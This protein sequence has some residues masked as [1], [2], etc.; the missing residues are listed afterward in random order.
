LNS[1]TINTNIVSK[2]GVFFFLLFISFYWTSAYPGLNIFFFK[3]KI[4]FN[5]VFF[6]ISFGLSVVS[7]PLLDNPFSGLGFYMFSAMLFMA[8]VLLSNAFK[9]TGYKGI[10]EPFLYVFIPL[11]GFLLAGN[12][13]ALFMKKCIRAV[14]FNGIVMTC[15]GMFRLLVSGAPWMEIIDHQKVGFGSRN[16]DAYFILFGMISGIIM[17]SDIKRNGLKIFVMMTCFF[18]AIA[19]FFSFSRGMILSSMIVLL[20]LFF[21]YGLKTKFIMMIVLLILTFISIFSLSCSKT[22][23]RAASISYERFML[24]T[25]SEQITKSGIHNSVPGRMK[26][27]PLSFKAIINNP[28][29]GLGF[30]KFADFSKKNGIVVNDPHNNYLLVWVELG[31]IAFMG[32]LFMAALPVVIYFK[33]RNDINEN[34]LNLALLL[35]VFTITFTSLFTNYVTYYGYWLLLSIIIPGNKISKPNLFEPYTEYNL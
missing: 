10:V 33:V 1:T 7:I 14:W 24:I 3:I 25:S 21:Y 22:A 31:S 6:I 27:I 15:I 17:L 9:Y 8:G 18:N 26:L 5:I 28:I 32:Y 4:P 12:Q 35:Y 2:L 20:M 19:I 30:G 29:T 23:Q 34:S 16:L 11:S 13:P